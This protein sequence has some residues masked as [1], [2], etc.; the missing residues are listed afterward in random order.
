MKCA[1]GR[2]SPVGQRCA[3][4]QWLTRH[5]RCINTTRYRFHHC[6]SPG[7]RPCLSLGPHAHQGQPDHIGSP[8]TPAHG[9]AQQLHQSI[10]GCNPRVNN[11]MVPV[12]LAGTGRLHGR[13]SPPP[14]VQTAGQPVAGRA[15]ACKGCACQACLLKGSLGLLGTLHGTNC[16]PPHIHPVKRRPTDTPVRCW[17]WPLPGALLRMLRGCPR[18]PSGFPGYT[19]V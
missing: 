6:H 13:L 2:G 7:T 9:A 11:F 10:P 18:R 5:C 12:W 16:S 15:P 14:G 17:G 19:F 8:I 1:G 3:R 4:D